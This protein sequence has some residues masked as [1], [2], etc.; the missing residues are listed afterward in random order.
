MRVKYMVITGARETRP[1]VLW[2]MLQSGC[3]ARLRA[4]WQAR[5][6]SRS[7][8]APVSMAG[9]MFCSSS[10][11]LRG[12]MPDSMPI[13]KPT[14]TSEMHCTAS[15]VSIIQAERSVPAAR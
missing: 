14:S 2:F 13:C 15:A 11:S 6:R 5:L 3:S 12:V 8:G 4:A 1:P 9:R 10:Y 7:C